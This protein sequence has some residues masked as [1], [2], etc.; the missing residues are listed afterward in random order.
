MGQNKQ[1]GISLDPETVQ[2]MVDGLLCRA[3]PT[4]VGAFVHATVSAFTSPPVFLYCHL[5]SPTERTAFWRGF[6]DRVG[7]FGAEFKAYF[8]WFRNAFFFGER[9]G[10][11]AEAWKG[12]ASGIGAL[13]E[14]SWKMSVVAGM[15]PPMQF[16]PKRREYAEELKRLGLQLTKEFTDGYE[17]SYKAGGIP[18][19]TGRLLADLLRIV[20]ELLAAKG[21]GKL[22]SG[23][24]KLASSGKIAEVL[25]KLPGPLKK[26]P[27][28]LAAPP[29][30]W[31]LID[32]IKHDDKVAM[33]ARGILHDLKPGEYLVRVE[34]RAAT[35]PG[36][37][38]NGPFNS[39]EAAQR[40]ANYLA[41]LG[42]K[43]IRRDSALPLVWADGGAGNRIEVIRIYKVK[44]ETP[45]INSV[46]APQ[47][48]GAVK[49]AAESADAA[50]TAAKPTVLPGQGQ[51]LSLPVTQAKKVHG[52][53]LV[54]RVDFMEI[55]IT[56]P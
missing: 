48:E 8:V 37:W 13:A 11:F 42:E 19:C 29:T 51:Q 18:E 44:Y 17:K 28:K 32:Y 38:F 20:F 30:R 54:E 23:A 14:L 7:E 46:V 40:Y 41:D 53:D 49:A 35:G 22:A 43:G 9:E 33:Y 5:W 56:K 39:P 50:K 47:K 4:T 27:E 45:G 10:D 3:P 16:H 52:I 24:G 2:P 55:S 36:N 25:D 34:A 21:A 15:P 12:F 26:L 31:Q 1:A 6:F